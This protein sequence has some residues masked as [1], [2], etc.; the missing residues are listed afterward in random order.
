M[1]DDSPET[2]SLVDRLIEL[3]KILD[4]KPSKMADIGGC[5]RAT[6]YRYRNGD[7]S[8]PVKF[9]DNI[10][11]YE[12]NLSPQWLLEGT[13]KI[14]KKP[15]EPQSEIALDG[16]SRQYEFP[17][18][19]L[20][21]KN[22]QQD[23]L[24]VDEWYAS[25]EKISI[26]KKFLDLFIESKSSKHSFSMKLQG[27]SMF[28]DICSGALILVDKTQVV[29]HTD[30]IFAV[31]YDDFIRLKLLQPMPGHRI[32][33]STI[34]KKFESMEIDRNHEGFEILG[35]VIWSANNI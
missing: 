28:P 20:R 14:F 21:S 1:D 8:P 22:G 31:K 32:I 25:N 27:D 12:N 11:D 33:L 19:S 9:L 29:P 2:P 13:G 15:H 35:R 10:L 34:N 26:S 16:D 3:E 4:L 6:Y 7:S 23:E 18:V 5:S 17:Y 24:P 30:G